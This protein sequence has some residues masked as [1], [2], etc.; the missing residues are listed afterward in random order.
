MN[1]T[2]SL[3]AI[4]VF[5]S[6][7]AG[8]HGKGAALTARN[9]YGAQYGVG[10]GRTGNAYAIPTKDKL[11]RTLPLTDISKYVAE[12]L[13]YARQHPELD[14]LVI[15]IGCGLAG[16]NDY[17]IAPMFQTAPQNCRLPDEWRNQRTEYLKQL[18]SEATGTPTGWH[19]PAPIWAKPTPTDKQVEIILP[20]VMAKAVSVGLLPA[21]A[22]QNDYI[23]RYDA[24]LEVVKFAIQEWQENL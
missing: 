23:R 17:Q 20:A 2:V 14:F 4:F 9:Q 19:S 1:H 21:F 16:Y 10:V 22:S 7:E 12:F 6:N 3:T 5:G 13:T 24:M 18:K 8:R 15:R 11:L